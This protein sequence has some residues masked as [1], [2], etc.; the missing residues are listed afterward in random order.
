MEPITTLQL[1]RARL[2]VMVWTRSRILSESP[3][4]VENGFPFCHR[5]TNLNL[6]DLRGKSLEWKPSHAMNIIPVGASL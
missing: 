6:V 4:L 2:R 3:K 1:V 5:V